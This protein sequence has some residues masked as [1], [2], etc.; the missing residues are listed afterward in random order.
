MVSWLPTLDER[1]FLG[2]HISFRH[3][4]GGHSLFH[5][6][7]Q[8]ASILPLPGMSLIGKATSLFNRAKPLGSVLRSAAEIIRPAA[9]AMPGGAPLRGARS[10]TRSRNWA[11]PPNSRIRY[12]ERLGKAPRPGEKRKRKR[13]S[14]RARRR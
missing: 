11:H 13:K 7:T 1:G 10:P 14:T 6:A 5:K 2:I 4:F 8:V 12:G 9:V 3:P